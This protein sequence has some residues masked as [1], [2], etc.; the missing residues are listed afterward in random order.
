MANN[1]NKGLSVSSSDRPQKYVSEYTDLSSLSTDKVKVKVKEN[2]ISE[3]R[4]DL[5]DTSLFIPV[6]N[7]VK[8]VSGKTS[9]SDS[10]SRNKINYSKLRVIFG[11]LAA[12]LG[13]ITGAVCFGFWYKEYL[14]NKITYDTTS[15]DAVITIVDENNQTV[16]LSDVT[17]STLYEA[18]KDEPV[19]N[20]LLIGIDSRSSNYNKS[21]TGDRSDVICVMS[22]D[23]KQGTIKLLS[24][25]R[26]SYA[27]FPGY[28]NFYKINAAMS[29]GG[30][31]LLVATVERCLRIDIDGY[32][33]VNFSHMA[34]IVDAVGG[35]YVNMTGGEKN[36]ANNYIKEMNS[37]AQLITSTGEETWLNGIQAVAYARIRYVGNGDYERME[38]QIEVLRS[39]F[40]RFNNMSAV[41]KLS[42]IDDVLAAVVTNIDKSEIEKLAFHFL[43]SMKKMEMQYLQLP[44]EGCYNSGM[45]GNEWSMR[46]NWNAFVPYVQKYFYG[47]TADFDEVPVPKHCPS[48]SECKM[49]IPL[50]KLVH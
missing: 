38:R 37:S 42:A 29:Y 43:P 40:S 16:A 45:Y 36:V 49:D 27:L 19:K 28:Q 14:L 2:N 6:E 22:V 32:A 48:L 9:A 23:T 44:I 30:P 33:Y 10:G 21:G 17:Q 12:L 26:D 4:S 3:S 7:Q 46:V 24:I 47:K 13:I 35:V 15:D 5:D 34:Q 41:G 18:I 25:A 11:C 50:E 20:Y 8:H 39:V 31:D 1:E